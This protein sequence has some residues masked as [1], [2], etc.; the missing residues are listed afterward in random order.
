MRASSVS[1]AISAPIDSALRVCASRTTGTTRPRSVWAANPRCTPGSRTISR[2]SVS[3]VALS[4]GN[5]ASAAVQILASRARTDTFGP[6]AGP[7]AAFI[8]ALTAI[9]SVA[10]ASTQ[11]VA[12]G[13]SVRLR[14]SLSA[15]APR[16]PRSG[17]RSAPAAATPF[18]AAATGADAVEGFALGPGRSL[19]RTCRRRSGLLRRPDRPVDV[20]A[21]DQPV[22]PN[23]PAAADRCRA[24]GPAGVPAE[25]PPAR[26]RRTPELRQ[27]GPRPPGPRPPGHRRPGPRPPPGRAGPDGC[28]D[29]ARPA[30]RSRTP[31][32]RSLEPPEDSA[33][34]PEPLPEEGEE[35]EEGDAAE[36][37]APPVLPTATVSSGAPT[38]S[39]VPS[40]PNRAVTT[41]P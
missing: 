19:G 35:E 14:D 39:S 32:A 15:T 6:A 7:V 26:A 13:I 23:P 30:R 12:S 37:E 22:R 16:T 38:G 34:E 18:G 4:S 2:D 9:S 21:Q 25:R 24:A 10:S 1:R 11:Q 28:A 41:P 17:I 29:D 27:P 20:G 5:R 3:T 8:A 33:P 36:P 31:R 40:S